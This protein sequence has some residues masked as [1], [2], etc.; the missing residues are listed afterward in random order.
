MLASLLIGI[1]EGLEAALIVGV[2]LSVLVKMGKQ[3][4]TRVIW[5]GIGVAAALSVVSA[6]VLNW[7]GVALEG[8][9]EEIFE[10]ITMLIA[11][12]VLTWMIFWMRRNSRRLQE[13][14]KS[15]VRQAAMGGQTWAL[16]S[17]AFF[18]V[19]R[20]GIET[21]L[22]LSAAA[23]TSG[24]GPVLIGGVLGILVA[25]LIAWALSTAVI[26]LD[27]GR[28]FTL[29]SALLILF[30]AGLF[31][32]AVHEFVEAGFL[33]AFLDPVYNLNPFLSDESL[34]GSMLRTVFGYNGNPSLT[35][36]IAYAG[37]FLVIW[38]VIGWTG[39]TDSNER[40]AVTS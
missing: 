10:G 40:A 29:T 27:L 22:F 9:I 7:V 25:I 2:A 35:E 8:R 28:F 19:L 13:G 31:G 12:S 21:A 36:A 3:E 15:G 33:P 37:Y 17:I 26:S 11:A 1:R 14:Y 34:L 18:A 38:I 20:E 30:A 6:L 16:F 23:M 5:A 24:A 39:F 4:Y 32:H